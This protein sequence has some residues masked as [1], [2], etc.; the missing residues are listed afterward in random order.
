MIEYTYLTETALSE[1]EFTCINTNKQISYI[2]LECGFDIETTSEVINGNKVSY[3]YI[4]QLG[5]GLDN[6]IY[7]G[8]TWESLVE[9][10]N[11]ISDYLGLNKNSRLV[12]YVHNFGYEFQF[13]RKFFEWETVFSVNVRKPVKALTTNGIEFRDSYILSGYSLANTAKN[14]TK[15]KMEKMT[16]DLDYS[17]IR[18]SKTPLTEKELKYCEYDVKIILAYI[19]EQMEIC[20]DISKIP[21]TNTGRVRTFVRNNCYY[22]TKN[23][24]KTNKGKYLRYSQIMRDLTLDL[25]TYI[26]LK[27][28]FMGGFTHSN[29]KHTGKVLTDVDSIDLTSSYPTVMLAEKFPMSRPRKLTVKSIE[30]LKNLFNKYCIVMDVK[31]KN[32]KNKI[33]YESYLS[34]SKC[35]NKTGHVV[36]NGRVYEAEELATTITCV[37]FSIIESVYSWDEIEVKNIIGF[38]KN[39]LPKDIIKSILELYE[40]K[41]TLKDVEGFETE[42][43]LCKGMLNDVYGMSVT[44]FIKDEYTYSDVWEVSVVDPKEKIEEYNKSKNRFLYY[45]WGIFV[46]AYARRNLWSA[47]LNVGEDYIYSDTDSVKMLNF[48]KHKGYVDFYNKTIGIKLTNMMNYYKLDV[49]ALTPKTIKGVDKPLGVWDYEGHYTKFKTLGA[50]RYLIEED[51]KI[52]LTVAGLSKVNGVNYMIDKCEGDSDKVFEMFDDEL[53]IPSSGTGKMTHTYIDNEH[54]IVSTDYLGNVCEVK[55]LSGIHLE[56][57]DFTLSVSEQYKQF[58]NMLS[59]GYVYKGVKNL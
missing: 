11:L 28:A 58:L 9:T 5:L 52:K 40:K 55:T 54:E 59:L 31:F 3:M 2:N 30:E 24:K 39:Y 32:L 44:D 47:I 33:G 16:G 7:Y 41:T 25:E 53:Y 49:E 48:E 13:M 27:R 22:T 42:Y 43:L 56:N 29:P 37:D 57:C 23:H 8:R 36:N 12:L 10:L 1:I 35:F 17:L 46:T 34:D 15:Y 6:Q 4:W 14:L 21:L 19:K 51:G 26:Q 38:V 20:G 18:N 45:P 50:K